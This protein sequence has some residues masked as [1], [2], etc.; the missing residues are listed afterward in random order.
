MRDYL[1]LITRETPGN[2]C[3]VTP[4]FEDAAGFS[5]AVNDLAAELAGK[6]FDLVAGIDA[7]GF[8]L[9]A[10]L[11]QRLGLGF[12]PIR[13]AGKLPA[14]AA[15]AEFTDYSGAPK[16]LEVRA[17]ALQTGQRVLLV[18]EWIETGA[19]VAAV[20]AIHLDVNESTRRLMDQYRVTCLEME[21]QGNK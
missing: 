21:N 8:I 3:D 5:A 17:G 10:A 7:L 14:P 15:R 19:Q 12:L 4:L 18:D 2:R 1:D 20:A 11:A 16:A 9:G 6:S 13:K